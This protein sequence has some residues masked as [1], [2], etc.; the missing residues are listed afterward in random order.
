MEQRIIIGGE[1][2]TDLVKAELNADLSDNIISGNLNQKDIAKFNY[3]NPHA[4]ID[5]LGEVKLSVDADLYHAVRIDMKEQMKSPEYECWDD[6]EFCEYVWK[7]FPEFRGVNSNK[8]V[9]AK[10]LVA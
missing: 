1:D 3:D 10:G 9:S 2:I 7:N 8:I 4:M 6:K 5:G